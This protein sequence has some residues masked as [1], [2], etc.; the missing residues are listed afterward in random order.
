MGKWLGLPHEDIPK[1]GAKTR[2]G[3]FCGHFSMAN[4]RCRYHGGKSTGAHNPRVKHGMYTKAAIDERKW[5]NELLKE[6]NE[7]VMGMGG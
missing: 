1:C 5:L 2:S 6:S 3:G 4:G 7:F